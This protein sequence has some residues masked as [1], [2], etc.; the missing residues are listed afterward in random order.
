MT[1]RLGDDIQL[2]ADVAVRKLAWIGKS[3]SGK[4]YGVGLLLE[5]MRRNGI[6]FIVI[7]P[8]GTHTGVAQLEG[9]VFHEVQRGMHV[10][11]F[12]RHILENDLNI[13]V[14]LRALSFDEQRLFIALFLENLY[15]WN[16]DFGP[17]HVVVEEVQQFAP[18][19][20]KAESKEMLEVISTMGRMEG[21]GFSVVTQRPAIV[22]KTVI[23]NTDAFFFFQLMLPQ[24]LGAVEE[25]LTARTSLP[26]EE[27]KKIQE[28]I[29]SMPSLGK[30]EVILYS[31]EWLQTAER[32]RVNGR[33][34]TPHTGG[35]PDNYVR[36]MGDEP[37]LGDNPA[38]QDGAPGSATPAT[39][40]AGGEAGAA[41]PATFRGAHPPSVSAPP[42]AGSSP[43]PRA[44][45]PSSLP[46][47]P[48]PVRRVSAYKVAALLGVGALA[49]PVVLL[50]LQR[51]LQRDAVAPE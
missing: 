12:V 10:G 9:V 3:G 2:P 49:F 34:V 14:N 26:P 8:V 47:L 23:A 41:D 18:Q 17:R 45:V 16:K 15:R 6:R 33:R 30:G 48:P 27:E 28:I 4:S 39:P 29:G 46:P 35:T 31:P 24:D 11:R 51:L 13:V 25:V 37:G 1:L 40:A 20:G 21:I 36:P 42:G 32:K 43:L 7:D 22:S 50:P 5:Q 19:G 38:F 44:E